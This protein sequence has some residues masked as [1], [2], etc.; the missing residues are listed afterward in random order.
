MSI[1]VYP[2]LSVAL[3][4]LGSRALITSFLWRHYP[5]KFAAFMD[6]SACTGFWY[7]LVLAFTLG[8]YAH[9]DAFGLPAHNPILP[10]IIGLCSI[11]WTPMVGGLMQAGF[12]RLGSIHTD[13]E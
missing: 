3:F 6:C 12:D 4:Y 1:L 9:I 10:L 8:P 5:P 7:G 11:V 2:L 13:G